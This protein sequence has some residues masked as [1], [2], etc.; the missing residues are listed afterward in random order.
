MINSP[1]KLL[2]LDFLKVTQK[3][4]QESHPL[5]VRNLFSKVIN[6]LEISTDLLSEQFKE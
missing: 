5:Q 2:Y 6:L 3:M 4:L 1:K